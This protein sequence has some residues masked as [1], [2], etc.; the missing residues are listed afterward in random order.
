MKGVAGEGNLRPVPDRQD[1]PIVGLEVLGDLFGTHQV[2]AEVLRSDHVGLPTM[3]LFCLRAY[4]PSAQNGKPLSD[5]LDH[6]T[7]PA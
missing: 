5:G 4:R 2:H 1:D 7:R 6:D 3:E